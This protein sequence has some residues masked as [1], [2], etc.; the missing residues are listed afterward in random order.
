[1]NVVDAAI[2]VPDG[3]IASFKEIIQEE[4]KRRISGNRGLQGE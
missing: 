1:L 4:K 2:T 3:S